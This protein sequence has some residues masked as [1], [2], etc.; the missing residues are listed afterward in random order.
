LHGALLA[1][2]ELATMVAEIDKDNSGYVEF[3]EVCYHANPRQ[4]DATGT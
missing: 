4:R 3:P 2:E 1:Q